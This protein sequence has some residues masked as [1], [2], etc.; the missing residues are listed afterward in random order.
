MISTILR[1]LQL[2]KQYKCFKEVFEVQLKVLPSYGVF[3]F[4][5]RAYPRLSKHDS[6]VRISISLRSLQRLQ[7]TAQARK[8]RLKLCFSDFN[9]LTEFTAFATGKR[10]AI[11]QI[12]QIGKFQSP[13]GV[14]GFCN[15]KD[16]NGG[17]RLHPDISISLRSLRLLQPISSL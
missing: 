2:L 12:L 5:Q 7:R 8:T 1:N 9:L 16:P 3:G 13:Y 11:S 10:I 14:Y 6:R 15:E 17:I 4:L